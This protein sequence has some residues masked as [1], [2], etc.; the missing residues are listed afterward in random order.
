MCM[1]W[2]ILCDSVDND[3]KYNWINFYQTLSVWIWPM[4]CAHQTTYF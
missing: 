1:Y 2:K 3:E 4:L